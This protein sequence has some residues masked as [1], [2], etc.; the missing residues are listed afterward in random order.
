MA[1]PKY[2]VSTA[3]YFGFHILEMRA[4]PK[5]FGIEAQ[6]ENGNDYLW[7][8]ALKELLPG[9][10]GDFTIHGPFLFMNLASP[11]CDFAKV[12][13]NYKW[14]YEL[15][16]RYAAKHV[17]LHPYS[18]CARIKET[19][20]SLQ[21]RAM[22]RVNTLVEMAEKAGVNLLLENLMYDYELFDQQ[23]FTDIPRQIPQAKF[24]IDIG[25]SLLKQWDVP[26]LLEDLGDRIDAYHID[27]NM[28]PGTPDSHM[29]IGKGV[30]DADEFFEAYNRFTPGRRI[31]LE[32]INVTAN[33][34]VGNANMV[35]KLIQKYS[36][37]EGK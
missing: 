12:V 32:Y 25:H 15:S 33:E 1:Y 29:L 26:K 37:N 31:V 17:V 34:V 2:V 5:N 30:L 24:L 9:R 8:Q 20:E 23:E 36:R 19:K 16:N 28:G 4:L 21:H 7:E 35:E 14:T 6:V 22:D 11:D 13:E 3:N 18:N 10:E 27:D